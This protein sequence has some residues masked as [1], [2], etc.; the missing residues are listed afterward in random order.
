M[1]GSRGDYGRF[2]DSPGGRNLDRSDLDFGR[3]R[4]DSD[5]VLISGLP[6]CGRDP[7]LGRGYFDYPGVFSILIF[8]GSK[9]GLLVMFGF[10]RLT[11]NERYVWSELANIWV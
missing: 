10:T 3:R 8:Y 4:G 1:K 5:L 11:I 6:C 9:L 7:K 2:G